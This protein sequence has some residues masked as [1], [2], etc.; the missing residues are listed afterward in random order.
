MYNKSE[1]A[2]TM[3]NNSIIL[4]SNDI[5]RL[6]KIINDNVSSDR[7]KLHARIILSADHDRENYLTVAN[8]AEKL[9]TSKNT[10]QTV[11]KAFIEKGFEDAIYRKRRDIPPTP[12]KVTK[13]VERAILEY[14]TYYQYPYCVT[15]CS[16]ASIH[17]DILLKKKVDLS[18]ASIYRILKKHNI[19]LKDINDR[20]NAKR[21]Y[22]KT[23]LTSGMWGN[24]KC[25]LYTVDQILKNCGKDI[26]TN[27]LM[28]EIKLS[29]FGL[30]YVDFDRWKIDYTEQSIHIKFSYNKER[31]RC[32]HCGNARKINEKD[33][34]K[35][36]W[37]K[38]EKFFF[39][40]YAYYN[41]VINFTCNCGFTGVAQPDIYWCGN[42]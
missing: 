39:P 6:Q 16:I 18:R 23:F 34:L 36:G 32:P 20:N 28:R 41:C 31:I 1:V 7:E 29:L 35:L 27:W 17:D 19:V 22:C 40:C 42:K 38:T 14:I 33:T 24:Q 5:E 37:V 3:R 4:S 8:A 13:S 25:D 26:K 11:R 9:K 12:K 10:V 30:S 2:V 21:D 15:T